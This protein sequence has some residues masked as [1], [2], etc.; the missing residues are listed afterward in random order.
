MYKRLKAAVLLWVMIATLV[1]FSGGFSAAASAAPKLDERPPVEGEWGYRPA[2]GTT[3]AVSSVFGGLF[4]CGVCGAQVG[5][6]AAGR[7]RVGL[8]ARR[9]HHHGGQS[10][11]VLLAPADRTG[12]LAP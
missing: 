5:R 4:G 6:A 8:S 2:D 9:R 7:R 10:A 1:A 3:T 11:R 12:G